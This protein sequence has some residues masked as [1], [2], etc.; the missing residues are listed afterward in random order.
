MT[1]ILRT[2]PTRP[3]RLS[4]LTGLRQSTCEKMALYNNSSCTDRKHPNFKRDLALGEQCRSAAGAVD[5]PLPLDDV[6]AVTSAAA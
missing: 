4:L 3:S 1:S 2:R 6:D 5:K